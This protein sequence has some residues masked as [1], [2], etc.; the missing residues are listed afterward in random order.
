[1]ITKIKI[2]GVLLGATLAILALSQANASPTHPMQSALPAVGG[3]I[4]LT[5]PVN[6]MPPFPPPT[7]GEHMALAN[8][9]NPMPPFPPATGGGHV[10]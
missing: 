4:S 2:R 5:N 1:M 10:S 6:P 7:G 8:P 3:S 9:V